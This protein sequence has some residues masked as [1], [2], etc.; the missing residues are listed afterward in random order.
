MVTPPEG[1][2]LAFILGYPVASTLQ[3]EIMHMNV[4]NEDVN[5]NGVGSQGEPRGYCKIKWQQ[6][7]VVM[8]HFHHHI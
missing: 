8:A 6:M 4:D 1:V 5:R 7:V 2:C 3:L